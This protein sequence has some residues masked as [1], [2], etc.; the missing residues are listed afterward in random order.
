M[1]ESL[2]ESK[3]LQDQFQRDLTTLRGEVERRSSKRNLHAKRQK[4]GGTQHD[5]E[6][7]HGTPGVALLEY[8]VHEPNGH[9]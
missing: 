6:I 2:R 8:R 4:V 1:K 9:G 7:F 3:S 5:K